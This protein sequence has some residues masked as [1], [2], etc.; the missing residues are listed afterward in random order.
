LLKIIPIDIERTDSSG[1]NFSKILTCCR[2]DIVDI[3]DVYLCQVI[4]SKDKTAT[5]STGNIPFA[6]QSDLI[7][8]TN[9]L[10][11]LLFRK[12]LSGPLPRCIDASKQIVAADQRAASL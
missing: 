8:K 11:V 10:K 3:S 12:G 9:V 7:K 4:T 2:K 1:N 6:R 5:N